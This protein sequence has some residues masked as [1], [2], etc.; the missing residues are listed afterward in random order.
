M[1]FMVLYNLMFLTPFSVI[2]FLAGFLVFFC[3]FEPENLKKTLNLGRS[4]VHV[5]NPFQGT[6]NSFTSVFTILWLVMF[7]TFSFK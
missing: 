4:F 6:F 1:L 5:L 2:C 7:R 3:L